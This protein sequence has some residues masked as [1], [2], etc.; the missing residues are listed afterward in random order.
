MSQHSIGVRWIR[1][2]SQDCTKVKTEPGTKGP[3]PTRADEVHYDSAEEADFRMDPRVPQ[4]M[5]PRHA[6]G[7]FCF[8]T[9]FD[10]VFLHGLLQFCHYV[11]V[12]ICIHL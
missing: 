2:D 5:V 7:S 12:S 4:L 8:P 1:N 6:Y 11:I 10:C 9:L 3:T